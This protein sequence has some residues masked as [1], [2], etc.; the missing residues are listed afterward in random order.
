MRSSTPAQ[1]IANARQALTQAQAAMARRSRGRGA[2][3]RAGRGRRCGPGLCATVVPPRPAPNSRSARP[4]S[5]NCRRSCRSSPTASLSNP[6]D[7]GSPVAADAAEA[8]SQRLLALE[9]DTRLNGFA[10][11]ERLQARQAVD[12][13]LAARSSQRAAA[14]MIA[15]RRVSVAELA[16]R[17]EAARREI[18]RLDRDPQRPAGRSQPPGC[19]AGPAGSRTTAHRGPDP[20]G[21]SAAPA[22]RRRSRDARAPAGRGRDPRRRRRPGRQARRGA[23]EGSRIGARGSRT[24]R[25][26]QRCRRRRPTPAA[27]CS[28][29]PA[30]PSPR[31]RRRSPPR[32]A[33]ACARWPPTCRPERPANVRIEGP[34]RQPGRSGGQPA[35]LAATRQRGARRARGRGHVAGPAAGRGSWRG[36]PGGR[37]RSVPPD[38]PAIAGSRS[39]FPENKQLISITC[40]LFAGFATD[41]P[42]KPLPRPRARSRVISPGIPSPGQSEA[43]DP[44]VSIRGARRRDKSPRGRPDAGARGCPGQLD[45]CVP[46]TPRAVRPGRLHVWH[47][48][49]I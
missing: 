20:A 44:H 23:R 2:P 3:R 33:P 48:I 42:E 49:W 37:Q 9:A 15:S 16:A 28:P 6:L 26:R 39:L 4:R 12:A 10:A 40:N 27:K 22:C 41:S 21:G 17:T 36:G 18:D 8:E 43:D 47:F 34:Y 31:A 7:I 1:D 30:M 35:A 13:M 11:Y 29:W 38:V 14:A 25:R 19:R 32:P 24:A 46:A 5:P 45:R